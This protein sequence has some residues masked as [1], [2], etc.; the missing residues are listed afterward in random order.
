MLQ[1]KQ[2]NCFEKDISFII[3]MLS[4]FLWENFLSRYFAREGYKDGFHGLMLAFVMAIYH[5]GIFAYIWEKKKFVSDDSPEEFEEEVKQSGK[6][7]AFWI[8][9]RK[10]DEE[11][12]LLRKTFLR[13]KRK[14]P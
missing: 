10:I 9:K 12:D 2:K 4:G 14:L 1:M 3:V 5:F 11:K 8:N 6:E 7:I 13:I